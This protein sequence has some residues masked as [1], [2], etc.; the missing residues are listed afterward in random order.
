[1][2]RFKRLQKKQKSD[3]SVSTSHGTE[4]AYL[5]TNLPLPIQHVPQPSRLVYSA[6]NPTPMDQDTSHSGPTVWPQLQPFRT[7]H[8]TSYPSPV[9]RDSTQPSRLVHSTSHPGLENQNLSQSSRSTHSTSQ[10]DPT[11]EDSSQAAPTD[12]DAP[13]KSSR[14]ESNA[15]W[16]VD[17]IGGCLSAVMKLRKKL[18]FVRAMYPWIFD[19]SIVGV[20]PKC[21]KF[22]DGMFSK[23]DFNGTMSKSKQDVI[24]ALI[25]DMSTPTTAKSLNVAS[26]GAIIE[27]QWMIHDSQFSPDFSDVQV[28]NRVALK[29]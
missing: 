14:R 16:V 8:L 12:Q 27:S 11:N 4:S 29:K 22:M 2:P 28:T 18:F 21:E 15:Y 25:F 5:P 20:R 23:D 10:S 26:P 19:R 9:G 7:V 1:M 17:A 13:R 6:S 3:L 24:D